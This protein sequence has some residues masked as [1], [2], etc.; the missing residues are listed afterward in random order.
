MSILQK[1]DS[2]SHRHRTRPETEMDSSELEDLKL[3][4][5]GALYTLTRDAL[6]EVCDFLAIAGPG[7]E[8]V[9]GKSRSS[10]ISYITRHLEREELSELEDEGMSEL[11]SLK[12][13]II[14]LQHSTQ[15]RVPEQAVPDAKQAEAVQEPS[16]EELL[17]KE[18]ERL[19]Q[20]LA[21]S[22]PEKLKQTSGAKKSVDGVNIVELDQ[23]PTQ[24]TS[25][26][27]LAVQWNRE[28]KISGQIGEPGQKD[29]LTFSSL[30]HQIEQGITKGFAEIEIVDAVIRAIAPGLQLRSYLEGKANLTLP[31]LRRILRSHYQEK[32]ATELYKQLTSEVQSSKETPQTFLIRALDLRQK[33]L[34]ASQEAESGLKYDPI[35]VQ[36]MFLHTVLTGLQNDNIRSDL[37][38][39]L[40]QM[41]VSDELLLEKLNTACTNETERQNKKKL[42]TPQR[43]TTVHSIQ[44]NE[45]PAD[46]KMKNNNPEQPNKTQPDVLNE[47]REIRSDMAILKNLG[48]E[49]AQIRESIRQ[50]NPV[51]TQ[52]LTSPTAQECMP[53]S[54]PQYPPQSFWPPPGPGRR[55]DTAQYQQR[56]APQRQ[57]YTPNRTRLRKCIGCQ[58]SGNEYCTHCYR[59]GSNEHYLAGCKVRDTRQERDGPLNERGLPP[60]DRE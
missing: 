16:G 26:P 37:Q 54:Q 12:D 2:S 58:Q 46:K 19:Q 6:V 11:L 57:Y 33:I 41:T 25:L 32:G 44:H 45:T 31:T 4:V 24:Q 9:S 15:N 8:N 56:F 1:E 39:Y 52:Y 3:G 21:F 53:P 17:K 55:G 60:R 36:S 42:L 10:L 38:P 51:Q 13:K 49:V 40:Q 14:D 22:Q 30:A 27:R 50:P 20:A 59:C 47:L 7:F 48:A 35:L 29:K 23:A 5:G 18:I 28:F 34:F 43:P